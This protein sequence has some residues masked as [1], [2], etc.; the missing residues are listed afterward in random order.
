MNVQEIEALRKEIKDYTEAHLLP[1]WSKRTI[2]KE[3][4]G[5]LT[6]FDEF[7]NDSGTDE[8]SLIA[9]TRSVFTYSQAYRHGFGG[10][11]MKEMAE[12]GVKYL[13]E[14]MW[15]EKNGGFYWMMDRKGNA[16]NKQKIGYGHSFVIYSLSEYT[17]ATGD[18]IGLAYAEKTFDLLQKYAVDTNLGGYWEFFS[19]EW[20]LMGAGS[21]GGDRKTLDVH[22]HLMEAFTTLYEASG[23]EVHR[24]KLKE[25]I[26][27]LIQKIMH[28]VYG[29]GVPQFWADWSVAPQIKFDIVWGW[30]RFAE[31]GQKA[32]AVDNT[33]YGHNSEFGWLLMHAL[34]VGK[35]PVAD[36]LDNLKKAFYHSMEHGIDWEFGG[37]FVEGSH[38]GQVYDKEKEFWQQAEMLIGMADAYLLT[39]DQD[40][41]KAYRQ[42]HRF[43]FDKMINFNTGEWWPLM[44]R[45]G[46]PIWRHMS[47]SWKINYHNVRSMI[48][49]YEKLGEAAKVLANS[50]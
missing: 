10:P 25:S 32:S 21:P 35:F 42:V 7:G 23:K 39:K 47:H 1:F 19:E 22:M 12:H 9:Q 5:Y 4:G 8:K 16:T 31:G 11:I 40:F 24:R 18:P 3:Y 27:I 30:D 45:E 34:R 33:S 36:Y 43:V 15:D 17:L 41:L 6:H 38:D 37:V 44:T 13:I 20:E 48:L 49:S 28:P 26:D 29:T 46:E 14:K 2:D 50:N